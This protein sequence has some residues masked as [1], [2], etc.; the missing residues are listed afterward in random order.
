MQYSLQ[1]DERI[2]VSVI[3]VSRIFMSHLLY[4]NGHCSLGPCHKLDIYIG[5]PKWSC[6]DL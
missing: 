3:E 1:Q 2:N 4:S 5:Y 6:R